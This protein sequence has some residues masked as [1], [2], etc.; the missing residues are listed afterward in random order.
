[1]NQGQIWIQSGGPGIVDEV[2]SGQMNWYCGII[3]YGSGDFPVVV[4]GSATWNLQ[5]FFN[6]DDGEAATMVKRGTGTLAFGDTSNWS[7]GERATWK[8]SRLEAG[9]FKF[10]MT[11]SGGKSYDAQMFPVGHELVFADDG[12]SSVVTFTIDTRDLELKNVTLREDSSFPVPNHAFSSSTSTNV[13]L[14]LNGTP[15]LNPMG[16]G[17]RLVN[18]CGLIWNPTSSDNVFAF[19][20]S[21]STTQGGLIVSNGTLRLQHGATFT[22]L[23]KLQVAP[24]ATFEVKAGAG[25]AFRAANLVLE[26]ATAALVVDDALLSFDA[27][28]RAGVAI[29]AGFYTQDN[30]DWL[31]G[32]GKVVVGRL[33]RCR[34]PGGRT[35]RTIRSPLLRAC[36]RTGT[37]P[38]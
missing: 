5:R 11:G 33:C 31:R 22:Q 34:T 2:T 37:A 25:S 8:K 9:T 19:S 4:P 14:R 20:N 28:T 13:Y 26:D 16:F 27:A 17:G 29:P 32:G 24:G 18:R 30:C 38:I 6:Q 15:G 1:M 7:P 10:C 23:S 35:T 12:T 3:L 36:R 21:V